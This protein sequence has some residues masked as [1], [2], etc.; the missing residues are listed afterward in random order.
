M[1]QDR[2]PLSYRI[3]QAWARTAIHVI[4]RHADVT[5]IANVPTDRP[6]V[7]AANHSNALADIA[8]IVAKTPRFPQFLA[9][10]SWWKS[11]P[12]RL[13]FRLGGDIPIHRSRDGPDT[14]HNRSTFDACH[15]A[16]AA[17]AHIAI[18]PEGEM[19][20]EPALMPLKTGAARIALGAAADAAVRGI[21]IVPVGIVYEHR[22]RFRSDLEM[23]FGEPI[24]VDEWV[25]RARVDSRKA[26]RE[27]TDLLADRL[28]AVT[29][30]YGSHAEAEL[31]DRVAALVT[32]DIN[33]PHSFARRNDLRREL[34]LATSLS[35][36]GSGAPHDK[37]ASVVAVHDKDLDELGISRAAKPPPLSQPSDKERSRLDL[38]LVLLGTPAVLGLVANAPV[39]LGSALSK[40]RAAHESWKTTTMGVTGTFLCPVV[41]TLEYAYLARRLGRRRALALTAGGALGGLASVAWRDRFIHRREITRLDRVTRDRP[42]KLAAA[43]AS[44]EVIREHVVALT[45]I[46]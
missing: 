40:T 27:L 14:R 11:P 6:A 18:F 28:A 17:G 10:A 37:L 4:Y 45:G 41:W 32:S 1:A 23:R 24:E 19:H 38:E 21:V 46:T 36:G 34:A 42:D 15:A 22:S 30:N 12:A 9:A 3:L 2:V 26:A 7:L 39:V 8:V 43:R 35:A 44:R 13:L 16:L 29:V 31:L 25:D 20:L 5:G 33:A